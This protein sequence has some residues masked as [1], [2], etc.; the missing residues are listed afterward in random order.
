MLKQLP[1]ILPLSLTLAVACTSDPGDDPGGADAGT[2]STGADGGNSTG[3][4]AGTQGCETPVFLEAN[5]CEQLGNFLDVSKSCGAGGN[6]ATPSLTGSC[7]STTVEI[8][9][10]GIP[11][12]TFVPI[13]PNAL[14][15]QSYVWTL[16]R[17]PTM[18]SSTTAVPL[19]GPA[20][21]AVNGLPIFG[22][23]E[24]PQDGSR[25]PYLDEIV[26]YCNGHTAPGGVYHFHARPD[27]IF[28]DAAGNTSLVLGY[29]LDGYPI[30]A[31]YLCSDA[32]CTSVIH[33]KSSWRQIE[34][35]YGTTIEAAW[36]A[37]EY[38]QG[39]GD[40][41]QCNGATLPDGSYAYFAT[42][43]FPYFIGCY[44]GEKTGSVTGL[45]GGPGGP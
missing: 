19:V 26:D 25:D 40:L 39:L 43:T 20:A 29:A 3:G 31:P 41:D 37:H 45:G 14:Q 38:V 10:N 28:Q 7:T 13:T 8:R 16:P 22:P 24:A 15:E 2:N 44:R 1:L 34:E 23:T 35:N 42:D 11:N 33:V 9:S 18:A 30:L 17:T 21:V 4:D 27:C 6:Y 36:D 32:Q 12:F 5:G